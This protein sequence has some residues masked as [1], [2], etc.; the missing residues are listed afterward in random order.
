MSGGRQALCEDIKSVTDL[1]RLSATTPELTWKRPS[2]MA[3]L[4]SATFDAFT[5]GVFATLLSMLRNCAEVVPRF[6][7]VPLAAGVLFS[8][9]AMAARAFPSP[10]GAS[11]KGLLDL[12]IFT[13]IT[14]LLVRL[15]FLSAA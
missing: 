5:N 4:I 15:Y 12:S 11:G 9:F 7:L 13:G 1:I 14:F 2:L 3:C 8:G 6:T 10:V